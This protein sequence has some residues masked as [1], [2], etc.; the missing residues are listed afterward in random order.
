MNADFFVHILSSVH[1]K[2]TIYGYE[3]HME[4]NEENVECY[5]ERFYSIKKIRDIKPIITT[6]YFELNNNKKIK[7]KTFKKKIYMN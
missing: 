3:T 1:Y 6:N 5:L 7:L 2:R 4:M